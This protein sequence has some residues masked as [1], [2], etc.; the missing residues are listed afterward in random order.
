MQS[1]FKENKSAF[2]IQQEKKVQEYIN[3][4]LKEVQRHFDMP[5]DKLRLILY[6]IYKEL[7]PSYFIK[8]FVKNKLDM[9]KSFYRKKFRKYQ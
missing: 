3:K 8:I 4:Y 9:I 7:S 5:D 6:K 1:F 2:E